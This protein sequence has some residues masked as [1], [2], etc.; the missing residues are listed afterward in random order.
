MCP[1]DPLITWLDASKKLSKIKLRAMTIVPEIERPLLAALLKHGGLWREAQRVLA[2][3]SAGATV[4]CSPAMDEIASLLHKMRR[5]LREETLA[6]KSA[7][8]CVRER[9]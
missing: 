1:L 2:D 6:I 4:V 8:V 9:V 7:G 5:Y 3:L